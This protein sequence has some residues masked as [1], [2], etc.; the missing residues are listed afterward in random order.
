M[1]VIAETKERVNEDVD[2]DS[3]FTDYPTGCATRWSFHVKW[4][5]SVLGRM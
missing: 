3:V 5:G 4:L 2:V 1:P